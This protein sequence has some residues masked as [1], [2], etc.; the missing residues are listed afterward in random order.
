MFKTIHK[1]VWAFD[2]E[3]VPDA[4]AGR[5]LYGLSESMSDDAVWEV[6]WREARGGREEERE[7]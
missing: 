7:S 2:I 3:W 6:M 4:V 5:R 1:E